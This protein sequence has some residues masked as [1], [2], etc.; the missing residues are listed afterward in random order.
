MKLIEVLQE[1][2]AEA[3]ADMFYNPLSLALNRQAGETWSVDVDDL[4]A[5]HY[6]PQRQQLIYPL[7]RSARRF[8]RRFHQGKPASPFAFRLAL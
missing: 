4:L 5:R 8:L 7:P 3:H 6:L 2:I 1:D